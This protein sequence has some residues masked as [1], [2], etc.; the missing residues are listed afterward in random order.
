MSDERGGKALWR[1]EVASV[2][3]GGVSRSEVPGPCESRN[4]CSNGLGSCSSRERATALGRRGGLCTSEAWSAG[5]SLSED[6][7]GEVLTRA[8]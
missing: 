3:R 4:D 2:P 8:R 1:V 6:P 5:L 7:A